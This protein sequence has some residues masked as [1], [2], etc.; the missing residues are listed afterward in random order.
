MANDWVKIFNSADR[1]KAEIYKGMLEENGIPSIIM[2]KQD[3]AYVSIGE[4]ELYVKRENILKAMTI[5]K[6]N[7]A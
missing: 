3:S 7:E 4:V 5:I 2:D 1:F 6:T